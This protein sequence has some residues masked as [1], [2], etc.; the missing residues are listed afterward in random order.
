[1]HNVTPKRPK[2]PRVARLELPPGLFEAAFDR[3]QQRDVLLRLALCVVAATIMWAITGAGKRP[4]PYR[5]G[6]TPMRNIVVRYPFSKEDKTK[7]DQ[8]KEVAKS[9]ARCVYINNED[10][11]TNLREELKNKV[12][13]LTQPPIDN[14]TRTLWQEFYAAPPAAKPPESAPAAAKSKDAAPQE[15][16]NVAAPNQSASLAGAPLPFVLVST[17]AESAATPAP[18]ADGAA[19]D[20]PTA[21]QTAADKPTASDAAGSNNA[22][23]PESAAPTQAATPA[24]NDSPPPAEAGPSP[25]TPTTDKT[26]TDA[27]PNETPPEPKTTDPKTTDPKTTEVQPAPPPPPPKTA[28]ELAL[29]EFRAALSSDEKINEFKTVV[30]GLFAPLIKHGLIDAL[31]PR[32]DGNQLQIRVLD[33]RRGTSVF[34][35]SEVLIGEVM[36]TV[37]QE[38]TVKVAPKFVSDICFE[39]LRKKLQDTNTLTLDAELTKQSKDA[40]ADAVQTVMIGFQQG[41]PLAPAGEPIDRDRMELLRLEFNSPD[42]QPSWF[43]RLTR[44]AAIGGMFVA[45]FTLCGFYITFREPRLISS[46]AKFSMLL[47]MVTL[48]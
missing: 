35:I 34:D 20:A 40:D 24:A 36:P 44:T 28:A 48:T 23:A 19:S 29:D 39:W 11:L 42:A 10:V 30:D 3:L 45:L 12:V 14:K 43:D 18:P 8:L 6:D 1:M 9:Q 7:T 15:S 17:S 13:A 5:L 33:S 21:D 16:H 22:S 37:K 47:S 38:F 41:M 4:F 27:A 31:P 46:L 25:D 26:T 2:T 32:H